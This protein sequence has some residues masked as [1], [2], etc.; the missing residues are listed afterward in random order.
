MDSFWSQLFKGW[1]DFII[2]ILDVPTLIL[3]IA[4]WFLIY[5]SNQPDLAK[6]TLSLYIILI[7]LSSAI[8]GGIIT[9]KWF[10]IT[11]KTIV[12]ERGKLAVRG[13]KLLLN[14]INTLDQ[15]LRYFLSLDNEEENEPKYVKRIYEEARQMCGVIAEET[16]NSIENWT[17]I[18]PEAD[19]K[20]YIG[21]ISKLSS[22]LDMMEKESTELYLEYSSAMDKSGKDREELKKA[23]A[24]K[25][26]VISEL[27][28]ELFGI[29][30]NFGVSSYG[31]FR[32]SAGLLGDWANN[33]HSI[34]SP[35]NILTGGPITA[36]YIPQDKKEKE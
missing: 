5:Q 25:E 35:S 30:T 34:L 27:K 24:D 2:I 6:T 21:T 22:E 15:R 7:M 33:P 31:T 3:L 14:N 23:Y 11:E 10:E 13:L 18:I 17:D 12:I 19:V 20:S 9:R 26:K 28:K 1:K 32:P 36:Q 16:V 4:T 8:V 29:T